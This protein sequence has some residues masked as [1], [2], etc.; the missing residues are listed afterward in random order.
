[1]NAS[2]NNVNPDSVTL[3]YSN[4]VSSFCLNLEE[5][6]YCNNIKLLKCLPSI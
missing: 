1:M 4:K 3:T 6:T 2:D 5:K